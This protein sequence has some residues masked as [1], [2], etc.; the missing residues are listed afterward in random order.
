MGNWGRGL[1]IL[2]VWDELESRESV[3]VGSSVIRRKRVSCVYF[4]GG[5]ASL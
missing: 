2:L 5:G 3:Y 1:Y 4:L